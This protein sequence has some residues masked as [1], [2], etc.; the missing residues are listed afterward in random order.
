M[1]LVLQLRVTSKRG[2]LSTKLG[3]DR[4][5]S[6]ESTGSN[7]DTPQRRKRKNAFPKSPVSLRPVLIPQYEG[8]TTRP[9]HCNCLRGVFSLAFS[10]QALVTWSL[11]RKLRQIPTCYRRSFRLPLELLSRESY[12]AHRHCICYPTRESVR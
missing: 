1:A 11:Q 3:Q 7:T 8:P 5:H 9:V 6:R 2:S 10:K 12:V 4:V